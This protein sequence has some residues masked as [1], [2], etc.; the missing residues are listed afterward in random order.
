MDTDYTAGPATRKFMLKVGALPDKRYPSSG[1][2]TI[3][4]AGNVTWYNKGVKKT[5]QA[6]KVPA[7]VRAEALRSQLQ[8][9]EQ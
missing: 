8:L 5:L 6:S 2:L 9:Q 3:D 1:A 7:D 4:E